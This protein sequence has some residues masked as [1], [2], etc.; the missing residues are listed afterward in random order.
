MRDDREHDDLIVALCIVGLIVLPLLIV[1]LI[2][3]GISRWRAARRDQ[4]ALDRAIRRT[5]AWDRYAAQRHAA[6]ERFLQ[7]AAQS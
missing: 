4:R 2:V 3:N 6:V 1:A 7:K 5:Q